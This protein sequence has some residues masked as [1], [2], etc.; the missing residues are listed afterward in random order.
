MTRME[1]VDTVCQLSH[2][3][4][5][6]YLLTEWR[7]FSIIVLKEW[8]L[9]LF[10]SEGRLCNWIGVEQVRGLFDIPQFCKK[11]CSIYPV[12]FML[13]HQIQSV[14]PVKKIRI[15]CEI[16]CE[17]L[18]F[19]TG[20]TNCTWCNDMKRVSTLLLLL[21]VSCC[22]LVHVC[23]CSAVTHISKHIYTSTHPHVSHDS[24]VLRRICI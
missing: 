16:S 17:I 5:S 7:I 19:S 18:L 15:S 4:F 23:W 3:T 20:Y 14:R 22:T 6:N 11:F 8:N 12:I 1:H 24:S 2:V 21:G 10:S 13:L 9:A